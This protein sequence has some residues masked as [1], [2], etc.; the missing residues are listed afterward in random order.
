V[1]ATER[2]GV[3][4]SVLAKLS[5]KL[6]GSVTGQVLAQTQWFLPAIADM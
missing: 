2:P 6:I 3:P 1:R 4:Q 5:N